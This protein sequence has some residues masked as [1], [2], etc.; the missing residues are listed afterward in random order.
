MA[1]FSSER[2]AVCYLSLIHILSIIPTGMGAAGY[3]M[4]LPDQDNMF[5]TRGSML[6]DITAVSYTHLNRI[7]SSNRRES[8][9]VKKR[10]RKSFESICRCSSRRIEKRWEDSAVSYTHLIYWWIVIWQHLHFWISE[11]E[12]PWLILCCF[13]PWSLEFSISIIWIRR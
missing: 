2:W 6:Q 4:P 1:W 11:K 5:E 7:S 8:W 10:F 9:T 13:L 12:V 3:T